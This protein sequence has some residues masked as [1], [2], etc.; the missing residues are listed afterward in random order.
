[1]T[2]YLEEEVR[3][4]LHPEAFARRSEPM[5]RDRGEQIGPRLFRRRPARCLFPSAAL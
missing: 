1:M 2:R 5:W 3:Q 4:A